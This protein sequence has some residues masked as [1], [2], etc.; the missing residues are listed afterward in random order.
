MR[1]RE[2]VSDIRSNDL[3]LSEFQREYV[4]TREQSKQQFVSLAQKY[5]VGGLLFWE[6]Q[7]PPKLNNL[8][9]LPSILGTVQVIL[10]RQQQMVEVRKNERANAL[11]EVKRL[12]KEFGFTAGMLKGSLPEGREKQ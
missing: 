10:D 6:T 2:L 4:W 5:P 7:S 8:S 11:K 3:V 9:D 12:C 1:I